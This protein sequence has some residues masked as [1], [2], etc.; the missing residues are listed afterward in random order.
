M[1]IKRKPHADDNTI[2]PFGKFVGEKLANV[3]A[4]YLIFIYKKNKCF[5]IIKQ[6]IKDNLDVLEKE[7]NKK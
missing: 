1:E 7:V 4:W 2:M 6:Y 3:P 5:G